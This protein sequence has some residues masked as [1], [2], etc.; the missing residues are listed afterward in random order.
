MGRERSPLHSAAQKRRTGVI[1][2]HGC[3]LFVSPRSGAASSAGRAAS[4]PRCGAPASR[5]WAWCGAGR[6]RWGEGRAEHRGQPLAGGLPVA[7]LLPV[8]A[9]GDGQDAVD[10]AAAEPVGEPLPLVSVS[11]G[12]SSGATDSS[13]R[14]SAVLT[15]WPPGPDDRENRQLERAGGTTREPMTGRSPEASSSRSPEQCEAPARGR[16]PASPRREPGPA[17]LSHRGGSG[18]AAGR[19]ATRP[20]RRRAVPAPRQRSASSW[21]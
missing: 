1:G 12:I 8:L 3:G 18:P 15:P 19:S 13:T 20:A 17:L 11:P 5:G 21:A 10:Q 9:R 16:C 2:R 4:S 6:R 7:Q 14:E